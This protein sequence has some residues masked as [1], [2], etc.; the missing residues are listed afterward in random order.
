MRIVKDLD[1]DLTGRD[2]IIVEDIVDCGLT[3]SY[4][5]THPRGPEPGQP[6]GVRPARARGP[7]EDR[8]RPALRRLPDPA[9][10]R[11]S[12]TASTSPSGTATCPTSACSRA[13]LAPRRRGGRRPATVAG[14]LL[15][16]VKRPSRATLAYVVLAV[17]RAVRGV[18]VAAPGRQAH[19]A[20][21]RPSSETAID[22]GEVAHRHDQGPLQRDQR[23]AEQR[24]EVQGRLPAGVRRRAATEIGD[25]EPGDR[26]R[27]RPAAGLDLDARCC[28]A[29]CRSCCSSAPSSSS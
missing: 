21:A 17:A 1:L 18:A 13:R 14:S 8:R 6:R 4:L 9:G 2:V 15:A 25:A 16:I 11:R 10:V 7:A 20:H 26:P 19:R 24:H 29:C 3:L 28:S 22:A 27:G 5:R 23:R 12:A